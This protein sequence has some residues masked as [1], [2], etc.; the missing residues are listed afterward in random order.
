MATS[1]SHVTA[2]FPFA[3]LTPLL[4]V[5][6]E[7]LTGLQRELN[8]NATSV[9][10][11]RGNGTSGHLVLTCRPAAFALLLG[12]GTVFDPPVNPGPLPATA[13]MTTAVRSIVMEEYKYNQAEFHLYSFT[14]NALRQQLLKAVPDTHVKALQDPLLGYSTSTTLSILT[15]LWT[16]YGTISA[17]EL[18]QNSIALNSPVWNPSTAIE[19]LFA[20]IQTHAD[21]ATAGGA[22]IPDS[23]LAQAAYSNVEATGLYPTYCDGWRTKPPHQRTW[24]EFKLYFTAAYKDLHRVTT[25]TAGYHSIHLAASKPTEHS[26]I[27][28]IKSELLAIKLDLAN[29]KKSAAV[30]APSPT[31]KKYYCHTHGSSYNSQHTSRTCKN[32]GANH[33]EAATFFSKMGGSTVDNTT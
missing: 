22:P 7:T 9:H 2:G 1:P 29:S 33:Q 23:L 6:H 10:S 16:N 20:R 21:F 3:S 28:F 25:S 13:A 12:A 32:R 24:A 11:N 8:A 31:K 19:S 27:E 4:E 15:H 17:D 18:Q 26:D 5:T 30:V 14:E